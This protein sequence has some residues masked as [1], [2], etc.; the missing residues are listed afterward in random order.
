LPGEGLRR[1]EA[2][3]VPPGASLALD[4]HGADLAGRR[5]LVVE[6]N[7]I[8]QLVAL[9]M[10]RSLGVLG[11]IAANGEDAVRMVGAGDFAAVLMDIQMPGMDGYQTTAK[12]R[13]D[14]RFTAEKL[15]V[16]AMTAHAFR[17]DREKALL[18]GLND[19]ITKP[20]EISKLAGAL[21]RWLAPQENQPKM[22]LQKPDATLGDLPADLLAC[23]DNKSALQRL[24]N[25]LP[26]YQRLLR[27][28]R[29]EQDGAV[30]TLRQEIKNQDLSVARRL[31]HS[32]KSQ[33][34]TIGAT[35]LMEAAG[36]LEY[37]ISAGARAQFDDLLSQVELAHFVVMSA[38]RALP[39]LSSEPDGS[40]AKP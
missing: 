28:V 39:V 1:F 33:A 24:G 8:N 9:E 7:E 26:F 19:F 3:A 37:A 36:L 31:A 18:A 34:G 22:S 32:L 23:L 15:P 11:T 17:E 16:I 27:L 20:V 35:D 38:L 29:D 2:G 6:D 14:P 12:I 10:L 4:E 30:Q 40:A 13:S 21:L 25:N 5:V